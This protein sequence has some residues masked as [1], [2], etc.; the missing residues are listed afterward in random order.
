M[1]STNYRYQQQKE[2][3]G[4]PPDPRPPHS[5]TVTFKFHK[6]SLLDLIFSNVRIY[7]LSFQART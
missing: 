7:I 2:Q 4:R 1:F 6:K 3:P 5:V